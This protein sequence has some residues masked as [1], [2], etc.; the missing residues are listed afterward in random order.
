MTPR[1][2]VCATDLTATSE[3]A[4]RMSVDMARSLGARLTLLHIIEPVS[5]PPGL[6]SFAL[7]GIPADWQLRIERNQRL[8][9]DERMRE[10]VAGLAD[11]K[12][13]VC[14]K[15]GILPGSLNDALTELSADLLVIGTHG[16]GG[17][18]HFFLGSVAEKVLRSA[19]CPVL[20]VRPQPA[21]TP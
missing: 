13:T 8:T 3:P 20:I 19:P 12:P 18:A 21:A 15:N 6:E 10:I 5:V 9:V 17:V 14:V 1:H 4:L 7:D 11:L 16:R 2:I